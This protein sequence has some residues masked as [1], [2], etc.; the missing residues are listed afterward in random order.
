MNIYNYLKKDHRKVS[1]LMEQVLAVKNPR[2]REEIFDEI[3]YELTLHSETEQATFYAALE[4]EPE[5]EERIEDAEEEHKEIKS[6]MSKLS[7]MSADN[8]KWMEMF[9]EF[10]HAVTHHVEEEEGRVFEKA[11]KILSDEEA[12]QLA[13]DMEKMKEE[14]MEKAA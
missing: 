14:A 3:K 7:K 13:E 11:K 1:D 12:K 10:K 6:Y 4:N 2:Q 9:G 8:E 5:A